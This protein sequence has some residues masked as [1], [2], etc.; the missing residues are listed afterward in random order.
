MI[1]WQFY[2]AD[3]GDRMDWTDGYA[4]D[5]EYTAGCYREQA[6]GA[7]NG[8]E[9][10]PADAEFTYFELGFGRGLTAN[11]LA[12]ARQLAADAQLINLTL[13]ENGRAATS[14][15]GGESFVCHSR[16]HKPLQKTTSRRWDATNL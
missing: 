10:V 12:A 13:L 8:I 7:L 5:V 1:V 6:P 14:F 15:H 4:S 16:R 2:F 3:E 11:V 9:P